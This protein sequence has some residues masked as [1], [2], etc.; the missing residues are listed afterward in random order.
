MTTEVRAAADCAEKSTV[1]VAD[2]P[3]TY[4]DS[5]YYF[6]DCNLVFYSESPIDFAGG[7]APLADGEKRI[8]STEEVCDYDGN[9]PARLLHLRWDGADQAFTANASYKLFSSETF[10]KQ[11]I[12]EYVLV[13]G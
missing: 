1:V 12:D 7:Y 10:G 6:A 5:R 9:C 4:I 13:R 8:A 11:V 3:Y 2:D